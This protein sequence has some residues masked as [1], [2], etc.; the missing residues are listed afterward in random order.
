MIGGDNIPEEFRKLF[1]DILDDGSSSS[2]GRAGND[3]QSVPALDAEDQ[4]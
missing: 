1:A 3:P 2:D 4:E